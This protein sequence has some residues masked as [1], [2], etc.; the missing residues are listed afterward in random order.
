MQELLTELLRAIDGTPL[1]AIAGAVGLGVLS[2]IASPCHLASI[3]LLVGFL[4]GGAVSRRRALLLSSAFAGGIFATLLLLAGLLHLARDAML[5]YLGPYANYLTAALLF[6]VGL[7]L[8]GVFPLPWEGSARPES[9]SRGAA[10]AFALGFVFG[11]AVAPCTFGYLAALFGMSLA[12]GALLFVFFGA[13][14]CG[15]I[16]CAGVCAATVQRYLDWNEKSGGAAALRK[17]CGVLVL[18]GGLY[19]LYLAP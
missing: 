6:V 12:Y 5:R 7:H 16:I 15:L 4:G 3:P 14:H 9:R 17:L 8:L 10:A 2:L 1:L 11:I 13:G 18:A 19:L